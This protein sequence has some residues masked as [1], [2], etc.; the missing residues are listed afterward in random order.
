MYRLLIVDDEP[1][2]LNGLVELFSRLQEPQLDVSPA[3]TSEE[4]LSWLYRTRIDIVL[5]D[6]HMPGMSGLELH[7]EIIKQ[8]PRCKVIFLTGYSDFSYIQQAIRQGSVDYILKTEGNAKIVGSVAAA[9]KELEKERLTDSLLL[10]AKQQ[11][12]MALPHLQKQYMSEL[13][14]SDES[15]GAIGL[16][17]AEL[18]IDLDAEGPCLLMIARID[19]WGR[20]QSLTDRTL[21][22]FALDNMTRELLSPLTKVLSIHFEKNKMVWFIQPMEDE[23][24]EDTY[25]RAGIFVREMLEEIQRNSAALL[26]LPISLALASEFVA[27]DKVARKVEWLNLLYHSGLGMG[28]ELILLEPAPG[29][30]DHN[31]NEET[32]LTTVHFNKVEYLKSCLENGQEDEFFSTLEELLAFA[33]FTGPFPSSVQLELYYLLVSVYMPHGLKHSLS[34]AAGREELGRY[35]QLERY[36]SWQEVCEEFT[37]FAWRIFGWKKDGMN[38]QEHELITK[39]QQYIT[40]HLEGDLSLTRIGEVVGHNPSYLSRLYKKLTGQG[41]SAYINELRLDKSKHMLEQDRYKVHEI[42][43]ELGFL[44]PQY[45]HRF[46]KKATH[47]TPQEYRELKRD[48]KG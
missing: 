33:S 9:V 5:S 7:G 8:W 24:T 23:P 16:K 42:A 46:F 26:K 3:S 14:H 39:I 11:K 10:Q 40:S 18:G 1:F 19:D 6:I 21:I 34:G 29:E 44:S 43:K 38:V 17:F 28:R 31:Y 37:Q 35:T 2:I 32:R 48:R 45:F 15:I 12:L 36:E 41:L 27:W 22:Q 13:L 4:A 25:K 20:L 47:L 30:L